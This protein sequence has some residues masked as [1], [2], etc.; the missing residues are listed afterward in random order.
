MQVTVTTSMVIATVRVNPPFIGLLVRTIV[1]TMPETST[2]V[3]VVLAFL[4]SLHTVG[5]GMLFVALRIRMRLLY[6][7]P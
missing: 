4:V 2:S 6:P 1:P 5:E 7:I 3:I